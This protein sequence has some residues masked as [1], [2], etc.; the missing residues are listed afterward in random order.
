M[1]VRCLLALCTLATCAAAERPDPWWAKVY[2]EGGVW[3]RALNGND[4]HVEPG[5]RAP[6][7]AEDDEPS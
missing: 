2:H 5:G 7:R 1:G 6:A 3:W 4:H